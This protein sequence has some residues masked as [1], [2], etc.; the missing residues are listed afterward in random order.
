M[1]ELKRLSAR[2]GLALNPTP[3]HW[4]TDQKPASA[5]IVAAALAG[6]DA[7]ALS[8][9]VMRAVWAEEKNIADEDTLTEIAQSA[10][11]DLSAVKPHLAEGAAAFEPMTAEAMSKGVFGSPF[12]VVG[13]ERFW[14]QDR[15][16]HLDTYLGQL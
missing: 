11:I 3:A 9:A 15:L 1:Q 14:G 13:D 6:Q 8:F 7:G 2:A 12:Y 16:D 4:P 10:G 5:L